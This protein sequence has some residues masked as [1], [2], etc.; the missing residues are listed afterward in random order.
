M[1]QPAR[2][3]ND[4]NFDTTKIL[5]LLKKTTGYA[6][7]VLN[8]QTVETNPPNKETLT[9]L[10]KTKEFIIKHPTFC[11]LALLIILQF[12][13]NY[14]IFP[15]GGI[16]LRLQADDLLLAESAAE[17]ITYNKYLPQI[18][19][20]IK[21]QQPD[22]PDSNINQLAHQQLDTIFKTDQN[23]QRE[24]QAI[25][26]LVRQQYTYTDKGGVYTYLPDIDS[27][28]YLRLARNI[29]T[30]GQIGDTIK[31]G[32]PWDEHATAPLGSNLSINLHPYTLA[33]IHTIINT[34]KPNTPIMQSTSYFPIITTIITIIILFFIGKTLSNNLGGIITATIFSLNHFAITKT[35]F[36]MIDTDAYNL[37]F[38]TVFMFFFISMLTTKQTL[39]R[40]LYVIISS[41]ILA[42][43]AFTWAGWWHV[44][45]ISIA[46]SIGLI[47]FLMRGHTPRTKIVN[48]V[49]NTI[50]FIT[51]SS[52]LVSYVISY[53]EY[54]TL[55]FTKGFKSYKSLIMGPFSFSKIN[56]ASRMDLWPNVYTT[57]AELQAT[58]INRLINSSG[59]PLFTLLALIGIFMLI[60]KTE[61][62]ST[63]FVYGLF[64]TITILAGVYAALKGQRFILL[65]I[66]PLSISAS[67][68]LML[69]QKK[70]GEMTGTK[71][72]STVLLL[73][74]LFIITN[75]QIAQTNLWLKNTV[76][77]M[78]YAWWNA[79]TQIKE[80]SQK[81]A[82]I[83]SWWD[84]GHQFAYISDRAVTFDGGSQNTPMAH[85][86][87]K[88]LSTNNEQEAIGILRMLACGSNKAYD[89]L[90]EKYNYNLFEAHEILNNLFPINKKEEAKKYL[91]SI[92]NTVLND[93]VKVQQKIE[94]TEDILQ[95]THCN[96]P[97]NYLITSEDMRKKGGVW[98]H[99]GNWDFKKA[100]IWQTLKNKPE[101][102][103]INIMT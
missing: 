56:A 29:Y 80:N 7:A 14:G 72:I 77:D 63:Q 46:T 19:T 32:I 37:M 76:P 61:L 86:V 25:A 41:T 87:G 103:A 50:F 78:N 51:I 12:I 36:G 67:H 1:E 27:Y 75:N 24:Q 91:E 54:A 53:H 102:E 4:I 96:P 34:L 52:I 84:F 31:E 55:E 17:R 65:L 60:R 43:Y 62:A 93:T 26:T 88:M 33:T 38:P 59:G 35:A 9:K 13:P 21:D 45:Y 101:E 20:A 57:V 92:Q 10:K 5:D 66:V 97:E 22:L 95:Y 73:I 49:L 18:Y 64:L 23:I 2:I 6:K 16:H 68:A 3:N 94:N 15:W 11:C 89:I 28:Y 48:I 79:L 81:D 44:L 82:I 71:I 8:R 47:L 40:I 83:T 74:M 42:L 70:I 90:T 58:D 85:W 100:Y 98:S 30:K 99:F 39:R 69:I